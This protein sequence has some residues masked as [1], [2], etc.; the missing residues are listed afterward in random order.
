MLFRSPDSLAF[1]AD[2]LTL[3]VG[4]VDGTLRPFRLQHLE[5]SGDA[6]AEVVGRFTGMWLDQGRVVAR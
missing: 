5:T 2:S 3:W 6:L 1:E 4:F